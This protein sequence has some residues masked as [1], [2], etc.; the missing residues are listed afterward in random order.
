MGQVNIN[1]IP[2]LGIGGQQIKI[3][4]STHEK[5]P[6]VFKLDMSALCFLVPLLQYLPAA[7]TKVCQI[8]T[9]QAVLTYTS[10]YT[11]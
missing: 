2:P 5:L 9:P 1:I 3:K 4:I 10:N 11:T 8:L 6:L 7:K